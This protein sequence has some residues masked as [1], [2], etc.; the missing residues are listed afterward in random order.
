ML[1]THL[2]PVG[3]TLTHFC[4]S[5]V[6]EKDDSSLQQYR[7]IVYGAGE[8]GAYAASTRSLRPNESEI[9]LIVVGEAYS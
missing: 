3:S 7:S 8:P 6:D 5:A 4:Q 9:K 2:V 1:R